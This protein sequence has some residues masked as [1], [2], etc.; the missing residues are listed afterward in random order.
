M[1]KKI[2]INK[3]GSYIGYKWGLEDKYSFDRINIIYGRNYSGKTTL[4]RI[5]RSIER[6]ELHEDFKDG[7]FVINLDTKSKI[8]ESN[9]NKSELKIRVYNSDFRQENLS[10]LYDKEGIIQPFT[11]L[12]EENVEIEKQ[13]NEKTNEIDSILK[14]LGDNEDSDTV[15]G[16]YKKINLEIENLKKSI[17]K[18]LRYKASEIKINPQL[19]KATPSKKEYNIRDINGELDLAIRILPDE[20]E[21]IKYILKE[22]VKDNIK[23]IREFRDEFQE[24]INK[25]NNLLEKEVKPSKSIEYLANNSVL[26][27]WVREG[28]ENHKGK[29]DICSFCGNIITKDVWDKLDAHFTKETEVYMKELQ[30]YRVTIDSKLKEFNNYLIPDK[31]KFYIEF[32]KEYE[33]ILLEWYELKNIYA[34]NTDIIIK[35][36]IERSNNIFKK[37]D[38]DLSK[39]VDISSRI[40]KCIFK[41]N[42][43]IE[44]N[45]LYSSEFINN[46]DE[47]RKKLRL[48]EI[49][50]FIENIGYREKISKINDKLIEMKEYEK[51]K[52]LLE[53]N[54]H[55]IEIEIKKLLGK[56]KNEEKAAQQVNLYLRSFL[57]HPE[58]SL[59][60]DE[61]Q[62]SRFIIKRNNDIAYNLSEGEQSLISFCYFL[63]TLKDISN[64][65]EYIIFIDDPICSLDGNN[66][67]YIFSLLDREI[68][69]ANYK[70]IFIS[71]HN[72]DFLRY[73]NQLQKPEGLKNYKK[74][75]YMIEKLRSSNI[76]KMPE[77]LKKYSTEFIYLFE[78]IH[79]VA[80]K[81]ICD[82]NYHIFYNF[83]NNI[84]KFL[85]SY[86]F[87][88]YPDA[89]LNN[90]QRLKK[91]FN[92][93]TS[94]V[95]LVNRINNE[96]SHGEYQFDRLSK[97]IDVAEFKKDASILLD[98]I[99]LND[100][101]QY[102]SFCKN[103]AG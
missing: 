3:F 46:Q 92:K 56:L 68:A 4:S 97:P 20:E 28:V 30:K 101:E 70:Q 73:L 57:G 80:Y 2:D 24:N 74:K 71:T 48:N 59:E 75:Y 69:Q 90:D 100:R 40:N 33:K 65:S 86:M 7:E 55:D 94:I 95:S 50:K 26:Q 38:I 27:E 64:I 91:F 66:I 43:I 12:G 96:Y 25:I 51:E 31:S 102:E 61:Y 39:I 5:F 60:I 6:K 32:H 22:E 72:M 47:A 87:F 41:I 77:Y 19:F 63:A 103:I 1:I 82:E 83:P 76:V 84:R 54:K 85:E 53:K 81:N 44:K 93:D 79:T 23:K 45:N 49:S 13:I 52:E 62:K 67:F 29:R 98:T 14:K 11:V 10:F 18:E 36:L 42:N 16:K 15:A 17:D 89:N 8:N 78:Q 99:K 88:K 9:L 21:K 37:N 34:Q 58:L 35:Y